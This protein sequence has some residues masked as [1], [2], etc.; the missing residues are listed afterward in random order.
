VETEASTSARG[1]RPTRNSETTIKGTK[2]WK[3]YAEQDAEKT[4]VHDESWKKDHIT[5]NQLG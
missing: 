4:D 5:L 1:W 2:K 3:T